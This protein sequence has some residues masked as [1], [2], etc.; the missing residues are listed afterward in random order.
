MKGSV[1]SIRGM[2]ESAPSKESDEK[3]RDS[4][5][6]AIEGLDRLLNLLN[7]TLD[8]VEA[9]TGA[10]SLDRSMVDLSDVVKQLLD[11]Y[12][13]WPNEIIN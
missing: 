7:S 8:V 5:C 9:Q 2:L 10:L 1:T 12:Q 13:P 6:E 11:L 4:T 3:W